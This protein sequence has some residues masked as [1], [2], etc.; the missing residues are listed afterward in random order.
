MGVPSVRLPADRRVAWADMAG[1][2]RPLTARFACG[3]HAAA[4]AWPGSQPGGRPLPPPGLITQGRRPVIRPASAMRML[5]DSR[6]VSDRRGREAQAANL[7]RQTVQQVHRGGGR[8]GHRQPDHADRVPGACGLDRRPFGRRGLAGGCGRELRP[9]AVGLGAQG[10]AQPAE[11]D[12]ALLDRGRR[13]RGRADAHHQVGQPAGHLDGPEPR[14]A[15][16][17]RRRRLL[18][19]ELRDVPDPVPDLPLHPVQGPGIEGLGAG[20]GTAGLGNARCAGSVSRGR[21]PVRGC[22][23]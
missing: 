19:G 20:V 21:H 10:Q 3:T 1:K 6:I 23:G 9:V 15:G 22:R 16:A 13:H 5:H 12:A 4:I 8:S 18:H 17:V 11:G 14:P 7:C 2:A